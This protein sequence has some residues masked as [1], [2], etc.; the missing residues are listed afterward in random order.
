[1]NRF[2][3]F[4]LAGNVKE[5]CWNRADASKRYI[6]GGGW[7]DPS[8]SFTDPDARSPFQR[9]ATFGFR[10]VKFVA[11]EPLV[12]AARELMTFETRDFR[13]EKPVGDDEFRIYRR[14]YS[15]DR[16]DL[17]TATESV[18]D[19]NPDWT[20]EKV[21]FAAGYAGER[22]PAFVFL[23]KRAK[24]PLQAVVIF[25]GS[26]TLIERSSSSI[27]PRQFD[28]ILRGG[29]A[30]V[31]PIYK[32]TYERGDGLDTDYPDMT[33]TF[34]DHVV[35]WTKDVS[36][37]LDYLE[38]RSDIDRSRIAYYGI[39]WGAGMG[40]IFIT[41]EQRFKAAIFAMGGPYLVR[42][43]P[44][45]DAI[46][47]APRIRTPVL[48]LD[49][50]F[51]FFCPVDTAQIPMFHLY[52]VPDADKRRVEFETGHNIPRPELIR[53]TLNWLDRYLGPPEGSR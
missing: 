44:E 21:S 51:D 16:T 25:P 23:P 47:F 19:S 24:R 8:Y 31:Y 7:D 17:K 15:Y 2:G 42:A 27:N 5:W 14:L 34:R 9:A 39:S 46:N 53:E 18:D 49:G 4:D 28:W 36:R 13:S 52:G 20:R 43:L 37:T 45:V 50:R 30:V 11:E 41:V 38:T 26:N 33:T 40:P 1:M 3:T 48:E 10:C 32:S 35:A 29:R 22:V 6:M 12:T